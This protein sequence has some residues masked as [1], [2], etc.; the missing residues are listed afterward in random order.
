MSAVKDRIA[1]IDAEGRE[2]AT[3]I[4]ARIEEEGLIGMSPATIRRA[5]EICED[6]APTRWEFTVMRGLSTRP[7]VTATR[8]R[9]N[10]L[11]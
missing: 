6:A 7:F 9:G 4:N 10:V 3:K 2:L 8:F 11:P 5:E 1:E